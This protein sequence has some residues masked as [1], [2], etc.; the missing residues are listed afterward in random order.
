MII[1]LPLFYLVQTSIFLNSYGSSF[2]QWDNHLTSDPWD[3]GNSVQ[4]KPGGPLASNNHLSKSVT[5]VNLYTGIQLERDGR[6]DDAISFYKNLIAND[7][8]VRIA[9]SQLA[10]IHY[11]YSKT[12]ILNYFGSLLTSNHDYYAE[13][14]RISGDMLLQNN[15][16]DNAMTAYNDVIKNYSTEYDGISARFSK[17]FAY[18][19]IKKDP[20][21]ASQILSE[22]KGLNSDET[23]VQMNMKIAEGLINGSNK[24][25]GKKTILSSDNIPKS[26]GLSQNYPN[27]FNPTTTIRYQIPK[28]GLVTLKVY[29]ILGKEVASL[30][31]ENKIEGSYDFSLNASGFASGVYIFQLRVND[32]VSSK[33]MIMLK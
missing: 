14:K 12:E 22:I 23:E 25:L 9:L 29:D 3:Q 16:F 15:Q 2:I 30:V 19:H 7:T 26:Y 17:L 6:I 28:P 27:P 1:Y 31:T 24:V 8:Y 5:G 18:L 20:N 33:K 11:K 13:V 4:N 32:Y 10:H 21:T